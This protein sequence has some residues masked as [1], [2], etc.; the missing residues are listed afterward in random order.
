[1]GQERERN[2]LGG[3]PDRQK[4]CGTHV[5]FFKCLVGT[6]RAINVARGPMDWACVD[7]W[8]F[9]VGQNLFGKSGL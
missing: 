5:V 8:M 3:D 7:G 9:L 6:G 2:G 4:F 1:M